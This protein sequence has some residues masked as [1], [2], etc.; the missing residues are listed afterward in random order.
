MN[1]IR[2]SEAQ[3]NTTKD[4]MYDHEPLYCV[5]SGLAQLPDNQMQE[6]RELEQHK[7]YLTKEAT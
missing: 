6:G 7:V 5:V 1:S 4:L 2:T 3:I